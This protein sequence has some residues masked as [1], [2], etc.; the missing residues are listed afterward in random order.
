MSARKS[1]DWD[2]RRC[3]DSTPA[4][5]L[6]IDDD[7]LYVDCALALGLDV[8][9]DVIEAPCPDPEYQSSVP[10][11]LAAAAARAAPFLPTVSAPCSSSSSSLLSVAFE[12]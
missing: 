8:D 6:C 3:L 7:A 1:V 12:K 9:V 5:L 10:A 2:L 4:W 11:S